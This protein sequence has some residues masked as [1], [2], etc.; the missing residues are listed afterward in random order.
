M[1]RMIQLLAPQTT[2]NKWKERQLQHCI[3]YWHGICVLTH[4]ACE[5]ILASHTNASRSGR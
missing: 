2:M 5:A 3:E 1:E 4:L